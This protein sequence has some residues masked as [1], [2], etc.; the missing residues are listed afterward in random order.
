MRVYEARLTYEATLFE[1]GGTS[2]STS[3][4]VYEYMKD[5]L[6][7]HPMHE[8]FHV[9]FLTGRTNPLDASPSRAARLI[10]LWRIPVRFSVRRF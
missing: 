2:L 10:V 9:I 1:V 4:A 3:E 7:L 6:E 5:T 8:V